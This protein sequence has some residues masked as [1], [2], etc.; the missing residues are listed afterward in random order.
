[1]KLAGGRKTGRLAGFLTALA[2]LLAL[3][4]C[5]MTGLNAKGYVQGLVNE[6][7]LGVYDETYLA[8]VDLT[9]EQ[10]EADHQAG[11]DAEFLRFARY[12]QLDPQ[13]L[14]Q[15]TRARFTEYLNRVYEQARCTV[16]Y[17]TR[18]DSGAW[19]VEVTV[20]PI[21]TF[22][23][24]L[25]EDLPVLLSQ[26]EEDGNAAP[27]QRQEAWAAAVLELCQNA[28]MEYGE[29]VTLAVRIV[30]DEEGRYGIGAQDFYNLDALILTYG[31]V[32]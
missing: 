18:S 28:P 1:M 11:L 17:A 24:L 20:Q 6:T 29:A 14:S 30:P 25:E 31:E 22:A 27:G 12:F 3:T 9:L 2:L 10:A 16:E 21:R 15:E 8:L 23:P 4:G 5:G 7:Y 32:D 26:W 19:L 13:A